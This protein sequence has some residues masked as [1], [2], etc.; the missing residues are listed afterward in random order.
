MKLKSSLI[1]CLA[2]LCLLTQLAFSNP[3][4]YEGK[5]GIG[6]GKHIVFVA[7]DHEYRSEE[8]LPALARILAKHHGYKCT[9][10]FGVDE[11][12]HIGA[13][14]SN[15]PHLNLLEQADLMVMFTRFLDL[16]D[17]QMQHI[18]N[19][20]DRAGPV[21]GFRTSSHAFN[22][23][24]K[25]AKFY[26]YHFRYDGADYKGGFGEQILGNTW[27]GHYGRNHSQMTLTEIIPEQKG[28]VI[29]TGVADKSYAYA[30]GYNGIL[31]EG[32]TAL[33]T[34]QPLK[35]FHSGSPID[36]SKPKVISTWV[37]HYKGKNGNKARVFHS[38]Q[39]ASE[40]LL[41]ENY[42]RMSI[43]GILWALGQESSIKADLNVSFV[44]PFNPLPYN[45]QGHASNVKPSD[46]EGFTS[47]IMPSGKGHE[48]KSPG[49]PKRKKAITK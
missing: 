22:I 36:E 1:S 16:P 19:Y 38:T 44:G 10:L 18:V 46:L 34:T 15:I 37:R 25:S 11:N 48:P 49:A 4:V 24:N 30:G 40:D 45:N 39:G 3:V 21:V 13:G 26:K 2:F 14:V 9:V 41:D 43:N 28:H 27:E 33:T 42:R 31:R 29:L 12:G 6:K 8:S 17:D 23:K 20:I 5:E 7:S 47:A 35:E 32:M